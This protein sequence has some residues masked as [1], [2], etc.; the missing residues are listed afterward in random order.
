MENKKTKVDI[1][2]PNFN[3]SDYIKETI[4]SVI[5]QTYTNWN[6]IIVD[7]C[8]DK[9]TVNI[10]KKYSKNKNFKIYFLKK[11]RGAGFCRNYAIK[12]S[13]SSYLAF[14]DSDDLWKKNKLKVQMNFM[15]KNNYSFTYTNYEL[16]G[17]KSKN[18]VTP[19]KF[20]FN[21]FIHNTAICTSSMI[22][23]RKILKGI[24][25]TNTKICEDYFFKCKILK[26]FN[27]YCLGYFLTK[28]RLRKNSLQSNIFRNFYWIWKI[29]KEYN[30]LGFFDNFFSLFFISLNSIRKY[31]LKDLF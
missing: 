4:E 28:Y 7:D 29:N 16:F 30:K 12:K 26:S 6:L 27:A 10:L 14:L 18:I 25:F 1:I 20:N 11:N 5:N 22:I 31:G 8:S 3:S 23:K 17:N 15:K 13:K 19:S 9:K 24:K 21:R 2:L